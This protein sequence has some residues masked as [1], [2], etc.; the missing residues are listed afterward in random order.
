[1]SKTWSLDSHNFRIVKLGTELLI[2]T[3]N[4][5]FSR[6]KKSSED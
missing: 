1:M 6:W 5:L 4:K 3:E 2:V